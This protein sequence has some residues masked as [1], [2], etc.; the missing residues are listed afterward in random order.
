MLG[1]GIYKDI[2]SYYVYHRLTTQ[3]KNQWNFYCTLVF[4]DILHQLR[5]LDHDYYIRVILIIATCTVFLPS[6]I[7]STLVTLALQ[8]YGKERGRKKGTVPRKGQQ[9]TEPHTGRTVN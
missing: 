5:S 9:D 4:F 8:S 3:M 7:V 1:L 2:G 6:S